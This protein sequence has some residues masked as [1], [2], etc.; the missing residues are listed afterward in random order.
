MLARMVRHIFGEL[1]GYEP[2]AWTINPRAGDE[3]EGAQGIPD[4]TLKAPLNGDQFDWIV[5]EAKLDDK[6][7]RDPSKRARL[8]ADKKKYITGEAVYFLWLAPQTILVCEPTGDVL[9][10]VHLDDTPRLISATETVVTSADDSTVAEH[11]DLVSAEQASAVKFLERFR[12]GKLVSRYIE[13]NRETAGSLTTSLRGIIAS[14]R[15][16]FT[17][18]WAMLSGQYREYLRERAE[19]EESFTDDWVVASGKVPPPHIQELRRRSLAHRYR[20]AIDLFE[21]ALPQFRDEQAYTTWKPEEA[22]LGEEESLADIFRTNAAYVVLGRL[23]FVRFAEDQADA[24]GTPLLPRRISNGGLKTW[25]QIM[26]AEE[27]RL[28]RLVDL[29]FDSAESVFAQLFDWTPFDALPSLHDKEFDLVLLLVLYRLNAFNF[30]RLDRDLLGDLYQKL[31]PRDLRKRL[32]EFYTD[33][34]VVD[35]ILQRTGFVQA[36]RTG[37]PTILD[38]ACGSGTFLVRAAYHLIEGARSRGVSDDEALRLVQDCVHGLDINDFAVFITRVNLLFVV[39]D[40][41]VSTRR[42]VAFGVHEANS[43]GRP[44]HGPALAGTEGAAGV[45]APGLSPGETLRAGTYDYVVGNPPYVRAERIPEAD[46]KALQDAYAQVTERNFDLAAY[47]V[48]RARDWLAEGGTF[49]MIVPRAMTDAAFAAPL[50]RFLDDPALTV[51]EITPLDW[52]CHEL[53]D[54]DVVPA[55]LV[56]KREARGKTAKLGLVQGIQSKADLVSAAARPGSRRR[57]VPWADFARVAKAEDTFTWP[58][59][60]TAADVSVFDHLSGARRPDGGVHARFG[61]KLGAEAHAHEEPRAGEAPVLRGA[62]VYAYLLTPPSRFA[63]VSRA[64]DRSLWR[65]ATWDHEGRRFTGGGLSEAV[66]VIAKIGIT[67]NAALLSPAGGAAQDTTILAQWDGVPAPIEALVALLNSSVLRWYS[68]VLLRAGVAGGGRRDHTMYP[69]TLQALPIPGRPP[70]EWAEE[71]ASL[72]ARAT[73][74]AKTAAPLD[75]ELWAQTVSNLAGSRLSAWPLLWQGWPEDAKLTPANLSVEREEP[76]RLRM[77]RKVVLAAD[78]PA[79]LDFLTLHLPAVVEQAGSLTK[80]E[81]LRLAAPDARIVRET[82]A[83]H[84]DFLAARGQAQTSYL[85]IVAEADEAVF[86]AFELPGDLRDIVRRRMGEFPLNGYAAN[87][88]KP[89]EPTRKPKIKVFEPGA[90]FR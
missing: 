7:I 15:S 13:V 14:L 78:D 44:V 52:C 8:W 36:A 43:L 75:A 26:G 55:I 69:R 86:D 42:D 17:R 35:Y 71:L 3:D 4:L 47:F 31:L 25:R 61:V 66:A 39:F 74:Q 10:E 70:M 37:A 23:L 83:R 5:G 22:G 34:E 19:L 27:P 82:L 45:P 16:Y 54:S 1:L 48:Y 53:F 29:A 33:E 2:K 67:L 87:Y 88:R 85:Q 50:R 57:Q 59:E 68:F 72:A 41:M 60:L 89:W 32:G 79:V 64:D 62:D 77:S 6:A 49:G 12:D 76:G 65:A 56:F 20:E 63:D 21:Y 18:R 46:R 24:T 81:A 73:E 38:P 58:I 84:G 40:L 9:V 28:G 51:A 80:A 11:L 90:R 30:Q